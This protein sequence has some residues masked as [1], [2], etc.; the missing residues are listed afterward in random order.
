MPSWKKKKKQKRPDI[1]FSDIR[2]VVTLNIGTMLFG[3]L[4]IYML[5][6]VI[7]Y[8]TATHVTS[9][10]VTSGPLSRNQTYTALI[11]R[12]E[13]LVQ[14]STA[15]YVTYYV[16]DNS[17]V[18]KEGVVYSVSDGETSEESISLTDEQLSQVRSYMA[19]FANGFDSNNFYDTY[20]FKYELEGSLL[21]AAG[22]AS[23]PIPTADSNTGGSESANGQNIVVAQTIGGETVNYSPTDGLVQFISDGYEDITEDTLTQD[24]F[25]QKSYQ[26][27]NLR[28]DQV[29]VGDDIYKLITSE[30]WS[31]YIP[32]T[33]SQVVSLAG[34][35][36]IRV[37]FVKDGLTQTG[38]FTLLTRDDG[39]YAKITF[40]NGMIRYASDRFLEIELVTN[41][42]TGLKIPLSSIVNKDFYVIPEGYETT[43]GDS[44]EIGFLMETSDGGEN[45]TEFVSTTVYAQQDGF[46]YVDMSAFSEGDVLVKPNSTERYTIRDTMPLEGVYCTNRGYAVFRRIS[47][48]DQNEEFCIVESG[49]EYGI[50]LYDNIVY[51]SSTVKEEEILY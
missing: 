10:Q 2:K 41:T 35:E 33:D 12:S 39:Y 15:G 23:E 24:A 21:Q 44:D 29:N 40:T 13:Q 43:G 22:N 31:L 17:K 8:L 50:A 46:Y 34:R 51:D 1:H 47:I 9:Y 11:L 18:K 38:K 19:T 5:V 27:T 7:M 14:S 42:E 37:R 32:L 16:R 30:E 45:S 26:Q 25:S 6:S 3:A 4:F 20:S 28:K 36:T 48:I 49:T